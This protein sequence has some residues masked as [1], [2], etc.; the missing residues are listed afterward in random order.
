MIAHQTTG[1]LLVR[2]DGPGM[3]EY[4]VS[5]MQSGEGVINIKGIM[6][7]DAYNTIQLVARYLDLDAK[8]DYSIAIPDGLSG[9]SFGLPLALNIYGLQ[10]KKKL[11]DRRD[12]VL[13]STFATGEID[14]NG[15]IH[16]VKGLKEKAEGLKEKV[17]AAKFLTISNLICPF[18]NKDELESLD[19]EGLNIILVENFK[20]AVEAYYL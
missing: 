11:I 3:V 14:R 19:I 2:D 4:I 6:T 8:Y 12:S 7:E 16:G 20:E 5:T 15:Q 9:V 18:E 10:N 17:A 13:G 1:L